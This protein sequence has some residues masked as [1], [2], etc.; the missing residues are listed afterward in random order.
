MSQFNILAAVKSAGVAA[1]LA[2][3]AS[4]ASAGGV[5]TVAP[6]Y[7]GGA[8]ANFNADKFSSAG[9]TRVELNA[10]F[11]AGFGSTAT[12][13]GWTSF[14]A[15]TLGGLPVF[16]TGLNS[17]YFLWAEFNYGLTL[18]SGGLGLAGSQYA[19]SSAT[20]KFFGE[21]A[22]GVDHVLNP[23]SPLI[24]PSVTPSVDTVLL[25]TANLLFGVAEINALGGT[26]FNPTMTFALTAAGENFFVAP[27]PFFE[28]AFASFTNTS[29][30]VIPGPQSL[31][32]VTDGGVDFLRRLPEPTGFALAGLALLAAGVV[33]RR[34]RSV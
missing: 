13:T 19:I 1:A 27:D 11:G 33:S 18:T 21:K 34:R 9:V 32:L 10:P 24:N 2:V 15:Y 26:S 4:A 25:G 22:D 6:S 3:C 30:G 17:S 8:Q 12:G 20:I 5:F 28:L 29:Q 31:Y 14:N 23:G 7:F 16:N